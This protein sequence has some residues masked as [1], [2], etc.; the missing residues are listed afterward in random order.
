MVR[1]SR[2]MERTPELPNELWIEIFLWACLRDRKTSKAIE[3]VSRQWKA[4]VEVSRRQCYKQDSNS[5]GP[6][7]LHPFL[8]YPLN[9]FTKVLCDFKN[10]PRDPI[11]QEPA[12]FPPITAVSGSIQYPEEIFEQ[13]CFSDSDV[14][15]L[16]TVLD[17]LH[18]VFS[19]TSRVREIPQWATIDLWM[20]ETTPC[21]ALLGIVFR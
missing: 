8:Y 12:V 14:L 18:K 1:R 2:R 11:F 17:L 6:Y 3:Q 10:F 5:D 7:T 19:S 20:Q 21:K 16:G 15:T 9:G 4:L 13:V